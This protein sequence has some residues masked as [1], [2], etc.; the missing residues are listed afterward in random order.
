MV[1]FE[2][3]INTSIA[4]GLFVVA[5]L[6]SPWAGLSQPLN[7]AAAEVQA[8]G[9]GKPYAALQALMADQGLT[10]AVLKDPNLRVY[11]FVP[12]MLGV[13]KAPLGGATAGE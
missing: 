7:D 1:R 2:R 5:A 13:S 11:R 8:R 3:R 10:P 12:L 4:S 6:C 9:K